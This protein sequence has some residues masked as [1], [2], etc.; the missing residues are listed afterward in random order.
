MKRQEYLNRIITAL[1]TLARR[2]EMSASVNLTDLNV[3]AEN[4]YRDF[5]NLAF[6]YSL[7]NINSINPNAA[8]IDLG[9]PSARIAIQVT[10]TSALSKT[11]G[12]VN[13]FLEKKLYDHYDRLIMLNLVQVTKHKDAKIGNSTF[14]LDTTEDMWD[15]TTLVRKIADKETAL[16]AKITE[17]LDEQLGLSPLDQLPKEVQTIL[18]LVELLSE[19]NHPAA[20]KG[21]LEEPD[22]DKKIYRRFADHSE[23]LTGKYVSLF[24]TYG[25]VLDAIRKE[26]DLGPTRVR[27]IGH[28]LMEYSDHVLSDCG[29]NPQTA[30]RFMIDY[31]AQTLSSRGID[32]DKSAIEFFLV[33]Q[34]T[35]CNVFPNVESMYA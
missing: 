18:S 28:Y 2:V 9:D 31:F 13:K 34:L 24:E 23:F 11:K 4:F 15:Y 5:L 12:T 29:G 14:S 33:E 22:P 20:G 7:T 19:D 25:G 26:S 32:Y 16:L 3:H 10:S 27:K 35:R 21:F 30:L 1:A 6:G 8:S 17:Y